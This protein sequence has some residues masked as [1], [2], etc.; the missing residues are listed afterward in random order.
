MLDVKDKIHRI[1]APRL[2]VTIGTKS[3]NGQPNIIPIN[4]ITSVS[5]EPGMVIV[6]V[7]KP[8][9][10]A[11]NL[12]TAS[13]FT[14]SVPHREQLELI[15]KFAEKYSGYKSEKDKIEEFSTNLEMNFSKYGPVIKEALGWIEC[16][17]VD[18]PDGKEAD[19]ILVLGKYTKAMINPDYYNEEI[20]PR[21]NPKPFMQ[22]ENN[23][24]SEASD[25]FN[26]DYFN[27]SVS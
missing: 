22:W 11:E 16:E 5:V 23:N 1:L 24:F 12:K 18:L 8:W 15:W 17:I 14:I 26:I 21:G 19:H 10:T 25:V 27:D 6:A 20:S 3:A 9:V 13:G 4:N 2:V 7:Y